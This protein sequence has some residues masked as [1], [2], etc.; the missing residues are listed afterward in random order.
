MERDTN[1]GFILR[2]LDYT[3]I[4]KTL[5]IESKVYMGMNSCPLQPYMHSKHQLWTSCHR[6]AGSSGIKSRQPSFWCNP[7][8]LPK[9]NLESKETGK[10]CFDH[11]SNTGFSPLCGEKQNRICA[12]YHS[13]NYFGLN[14]KKSSTERIRLLC[15][16]A[17][18][19]A[20]SNFKTSCS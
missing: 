13:L 9:M 3:S 1:S 15:V 7:R 18:L 2:I 4:V 6:I 17:Q 11:W 20:L 5:Q 14:L 19:I 8:L 12:G 10:N 16:K